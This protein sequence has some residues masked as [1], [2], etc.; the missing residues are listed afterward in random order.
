MTMP[1]RKQ[2]KMKKKNKANAIKNKIISSEKAI[3][4]AK[5]KA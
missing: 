4:A 1:N 5:A 2:M 3:V